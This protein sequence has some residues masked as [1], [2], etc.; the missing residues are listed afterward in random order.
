[1]PKGAWE[2]EHWMTWKSY[3]DKDRFDFRHELEYGVTDRFQLALYLIDWRYEDFEDGGSETTYQNTAIEAIYNLTDPVTSLLGSALYGEVKLG[4]KKFA[5]EGKVLLQKDWG[6][7]SAVYN[8]T[9]EAEWEGDGLDSLNEKK[10]EI[11]NSAGLSY[12]IT[13]SFLVGVEALHEFEIDDWDERGDDAVYVG[14]NISFRKGSFFATAAWL[15][16]ATSVGG[17]ADHQLRV[18]VGINF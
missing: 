3:D 2:F 18:L 1:M 4:D 5:M 6:P 14:P 7:L 15:G 11:K 10:G 12:Q 9:L 17:E 16:Q 8:F 13:P